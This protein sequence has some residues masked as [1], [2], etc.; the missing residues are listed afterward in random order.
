VQKLLKNLYWYWLTRNKYTIILL[1]LITMYA[2]DLFKLNRQSKRLNEGLEKT[3]GKKINLENF[4]LDKLQDARNKI[5]TQLSQIRDTAGFNENLENDAYH[6]AQFM[7]DAINAEIAEREEFIIDSSENITGEEMKVQEGSAHGYN[8]VKWY[9]K[10]GDQIKLTKWLRKEAGLPKDAPVYFDDA[11]LVW[12]D[13]TIV[14]DAL[15]DPKLKFNDLLDAVIKASGTKAPA[16]ARQQGVYRRPGVPPM[17]E[18]PGTWKGES[19]EP[20]EDMRNLREGEIQ[21]ASAIVTA[22]T[23]VDRVGRW[24]E[25]LSGMENDTLLQLGDSIR[26]EMGQEQAKAFISSVAPAI[27]QALENL[28]T[29]RETLASG[30]RVL[31]GEE[32]GAEMLGAEAG[33]PAGDEGGDMGAD[34][35]EPAPEMGAEE[36]A[37][38]EF[39]AADAAAG[40]AEAAGREKR[41]SIDFQNR[42]MKVL[43]G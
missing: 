15:V 29:T 38:D 40:G 2:K 14:R 39:G 4:D 19:V 8:V 5:R 10:H 3:F 11:D 9:N 24:I 27:Q 6:Q 13:E 33:A 28:K 26:D 1:E 41:E 22:K 36:P 23:M 34:M 31:T 35:Q 7:L 12:E 16:Y 17:Q 20:G 21:Q 37:G 43:A 25:E 42:L 30:V 18:F 32:Q